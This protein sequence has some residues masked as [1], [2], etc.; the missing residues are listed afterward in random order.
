MNLNDI[1]DL[2]QN[3]ANSFSFRQYTDSTIID[4][5]EYTM[6][7]SGKHVRPILVL[8]GAYLNQDDLSEVLPLAH[9][10]ETFHN[11]TLMHDDI[12]DQSQI[13]RGK[14]SSY[15]KF[16]VVNTILSGDAM[17]VLVY[18]QFSQYAKFHTQPNIFKLFNQTALEVCIGQQM[19]IDFEN[20]QFV[21]VNEYLE[22]IRLKTA[23]LL[24]V[25][26]QI[27]GVAADMP[28]P[29]TQQLYACIEKAGLAFQ[30]Q[31]DLLDYFG[32]PELTGK[33]KGN[34]IK[35]NKKT[36]LTTLLYHSLSPA[37]KELFD[38]TLLESMP[39]DEKI[40]FFDYKFEQNNIKSNVE[41]YIKQLFEESHAIID[42]LDIPN[43]KKYLLESLII[44]LSNRKH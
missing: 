27:G 8:L 38:F 34:D 26:I 33:A 24:G 20:R 19:D 6:E 30:I 39:F 44:N 15:V 40:H 21:S 43:E 16:G 14:P 3:Y 2:Y 28:F 9:A 29:I 35:N 36:Y 13:R 42:A 10:I 23:V 5:I 17:Q 1:K 22:M 37:E 11:F 41:H 4:P 7:A 32:D 18:Q 25:S 12:M 31:D